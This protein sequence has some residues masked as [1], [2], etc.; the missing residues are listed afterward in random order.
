MFHRALNHSKEKKQ[1]RTKSCWQLSGF[2]TTVGFVHF[3][4]AKS[5]TRTHS[6]NTHP[7]TTSTT[8]KTRS[9]TVAKVLVFSWFPI[10][11]LDMDNFTA[12]ARC[13][14][15]LVSRQFPGALATA[16]C[17]LEDVNCPAFTYIYICIIIYSRQ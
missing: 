14:V 3:L 8:R 13:A 17:V 15:T 12:R 4:H 10:F 16:S 5:H 7:N 11:F 9:L 2:Y 6:R 1:E